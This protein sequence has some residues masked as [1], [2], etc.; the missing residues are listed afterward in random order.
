MG[1]GRD[2]QGRGGSQEEGLTL[3]RS[4]ENLLLEKFPTLVFNFHSVLNYLVPGV[5]PQFYCLGLVPLH[6]NYQKFH[7]SCR[8]SL[9]LFLGFKTSKFGL[10][11]FYVSWSF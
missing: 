3:K 4:H 10:F 2:R 7:E 6:Q 5:V 1:R 8:M 9:A 11:C